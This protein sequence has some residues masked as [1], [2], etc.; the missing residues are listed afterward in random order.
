MTSAADSPK[1]R[2]S[3]RTVREWPARR[4]LQ[5]LLVAVLLAAVAKLIYGPM[6]WSKE[7]LRRVRKEAPE[8]TD[9]KAMV[10]LPG[11]LRSETLH[12]EVL[13]AQEH[14][15]IGVWHGC[16][17]VAGV[18]VFLLATG[19]WWMPRA[20]GDGTPAEPPQ[21]APEAPEAD[22]AAAVAPGAARFRLLWWGL[23]LAAVV[24][25]S[26]W[27]LPR[28]DHSLWNDE[29]YAMR[30]LAHGAV[31]NGEFKPVPWSATYF[32]NHHGNNHL[33]HTTLSRA[34]LDAWKAFE[35]R[36]PSDFSERAVRMPS[37]LASLATLVLIGLVGRQLGG[38]WL[39]LGAAWFL[40]LNPWHIRYSA[41]AKGYS[42]CLCFICL[43]VFALVRAL[44]TGR[45]GA[46]LLFGLAEAAFLLS[47]AGTLAVAVGLNV[48]A[49][50]DCL[51]RRR[52]RQ[53]ATLAAFNLIGAIPV[54]V[55]MLPS[56]PQLSAFMVHGKDLRLPANTE[57]LVGLGAHLLTGFQEVNPQPEDHLGTSWEMLRA[58]HPV[59]VPAV[60]WAFVGLAAVGLVMAARST[61]GRVAVL[62]I[63]LG[64]A[65]SFWHAAVQH[66]PNLAMYYIYTLIPLALACPLALVAWR[67]RPQ[68]LTP[69]LMAVFLG[70]YAVASHRPREIFAEHDRQ[71]IREAV[72][73]TRD[74]HPD[75]LTGTF[76]VSDRQ[77]LSYDRG[78]RLIKTPADVDD[79]LAEGKKRGQ[80]VFIYICGLRESS[81]RV[82]ELVARVVGSEDFVPH[83]VLPGHEAMFTYHVYQA[84]P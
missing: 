81:V 73:T 82:P 2:F 72:A 65:L 47:F 51:V 16:A 5:A 59:L 49:V 70:A 20:E 22:A 41:E 37:F 28:M 71:P 25:A 69:V 50:V 38:P 17:L 31:E 61:A 79:L 36:R 60:G 77:A 35:E 67:W 46:W 66:H 12:P 30:R 24:T 75:V 74:G 48:A 13:R 78:V 45:L 54:L 15:V 76:G 44:R 11:W 42:L 32:E 7:I 68:W 84:R 56:V 53:I 8:F 62:G 1:F 29:E 3:L 52:P 43:A 18:C 63:A 34:S 6:P 4:W 26:L 21:R 19:R 64:G 33:L 58:A 27:R 57:W 23:L 39:G 55:W 10:T 80:P 14:G 40:A 83:A 9:P